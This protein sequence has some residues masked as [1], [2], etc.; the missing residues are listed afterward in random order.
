[1][2]RKE[3]V[4]QHCNGVESQVEVEHHPYEELLMPFATQ[5]AGH[6]SEGDGQRTFLKH[7]DGR[8]L[9]P[10]QGEEIK[11]REKEADYE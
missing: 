4:Q 9:K 2:M 3:D 7:K 5:I 11:N 8:L 1:M 10:L 6:G